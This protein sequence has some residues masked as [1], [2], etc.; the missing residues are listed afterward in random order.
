MANKQ[1]KAEG[2]RKEPKLPKS[3]FA[4]GL[5]SDTLENLE[6]YALSIVENES[7]AN[8]EAQH[9]GFD[10]VL[11]QHIRLS[12]TRL[13]KVHLLDCRLAACDLANGEW[14]EASLQRL[15]L[16]DCHLTGFRAIEA[17]LQDVLFQEC[18]GSFVQLR[19]AVLKTVQFERCN[20]S[21]IDLSGATLTNVSFVDCDLREADLSGATLVNVDLRGS[22]IDG[23]H[24]GV[25][26][27]KG[28]TLD[29][30]QALAFVRGL[31]IKVETAEGPGDMRGRADLYVG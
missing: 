22:K 27:L 11:F 12:N 5:D 4:K 8:Q 30:T 17:R 21:G 9:V 1:S 18:S 14:L 29:H 15:E 31:G 25:Q 16:L 19:F 13:K 3:G 6:K 7:F 10:Q 24:A 23:M 28:T 20:L 26:E 2:V